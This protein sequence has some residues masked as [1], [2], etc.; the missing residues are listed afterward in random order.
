MESQCVTTSHNSSLMGMLTRWPLTLNQPFAFPSLMTSQN[1]SRRC[2]DA[3]MT[4]TAVR[5]R[6]IGSRLTA[7]SYAC[8]V[9]A[10]LGNSVPSSQFP[11]ES[12]RRSLLV[13]ALR[14]WL[15]LILMMWG[16]QLTVQSIA[17]NS[18]SSLCLQSSSSILASVVECEVSHL[19][20]RHNELCKVIN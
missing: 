20:H 9:G 5:A 7:S 10:V 17:L 19:K 4:H 8:W 13:N 1:A 3:R 6:A 15:V 18:W 16:K 2:P 14:M 12:I 11:S